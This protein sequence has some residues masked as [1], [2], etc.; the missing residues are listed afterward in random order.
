MNP[1]LRNYCI[2]EVQK[3]KFIFNKD[4]TIEVQDGVIFW[5][6]FSGK[7]NS[8]G[9]SRRNFNVAITK[10]V[11]D[12]L[13][14]DP[15]GR[16]N[17]HTEVDEEDP[18]KPV[19]FYYVNVKIKL[20]NLEPGAITLF[21]TYGNRKSKRMLD[22]VTIGCL[23]GLLNDASFD[24]VINPWAY[25]RPGNNEPTVSAYLRKMF[26]RHDQKPIFGGKYDDFIDVD[27][28]PVVPMLDMKNADV[29]DAEFSVVSDNEH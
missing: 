6:N 26:I 15:R 16:W 20:E 19:V 7:P 29:I 17:I 28:A 5:T 12:E 1:N 13:A 14:N 23:D 8:F 10:E 24:F 21:T 18:L 2:Q 4:G 22:E 11:A 3:S 9:D 25:Q 27:P